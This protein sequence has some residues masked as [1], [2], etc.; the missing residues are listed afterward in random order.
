MIEIRAFTEDIDR[1]YLA[2]C[3]YARAEIVKADDRK[4]SMLDASVK[5]WIVHKDDRLFC[6]AGVVR[7]SLLGEPATLWVLYGKRVAEKP[8]W[9]IR[10]AKEV[11]PI[12]TEMY[13]RLRTFV[14]DDFEPGK[15]FVEMFGF[16]KVSS[17]GSH[18][19]YEAN[20]GV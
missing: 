2:L 19:L 6:I 1:Y 10:T 14:R 18:V 3:P 8:F 9:A 5:K 7:K 12:L 15:K 13:P 16:K 11:L 20:Y 17:V 4:Q